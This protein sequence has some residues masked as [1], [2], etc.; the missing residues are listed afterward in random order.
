MARH[1]S[2][3]KRFLN[4]GKKFIS[5]YDL[6]NEYGVENCKIELIEYFKCDS[7]DGLFEFIRN[8]RKR[9]ETA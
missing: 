3:Y 8:R 2:D 7:L 1:R 4:S 9:I 6:F 5:S